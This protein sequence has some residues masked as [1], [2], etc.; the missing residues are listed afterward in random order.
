[1]SRY[2]DTSTKHKWRKSWSSMEDPVVLLE[3][4]LY[5]HF[6]A[7]LSWERQFEK[8]VLEHGGE[9]VPNWDCLFVNRKQGLFLSV[10]G[11]Y[12]K[13]RKETKSGPNVEDIYE[14]SWFGR[15][16]IILWPCSFGLHSTRMQHK[17]TYCGQLQGY[18]WIQD[19]SWRYTKL[20]YSENSEAN[21]S[22]WSYDC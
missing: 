13:G 4:N 8:V 6:F 12:Q 17:Q 16:N 18:V 19:V 22:S 3:R 9:K 15:T 5:D 10:C 7:G 21:I 1:M 2:L 11:R 20:F 14:R